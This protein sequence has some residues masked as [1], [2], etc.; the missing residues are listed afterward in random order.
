VQ[1]DTFVNY[2]H[3]RWLWV[4]VAFLAILVVLYV[5]DAPLKGPRG[6]TL[7][8][9]TYGGLATAGILYLMWY[10]KRKRSYRA[11]TTTLKGCLS[12]HVW[13]GISLAIIVPLH[14]GFSF[15]WNV[16]TLTY[17]LMMVV[18]LSGI[19]GAYH[20]VRL[21]PEIESHRGGGNLKKLLEQV[22]LLSSEIE[23]LIKD[24]SDAFL[25]LVREVDFPFEPSANLNTA[26]LPDPS[27]PRVTELASKLIETE[28][29][30]GLKLLS[31]VTK[32][33][34]FVSRISHEVRTTTRL[35]SWLYLHLPLSFA[36]LVC[37]AIHIFT[38]LYYR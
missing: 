37:L 2:R 27:N 19:W 5:I 26:K 13:L 16:H 33:R 36:L 18:V 1:V 34:E 29:S 17:I 3:Y 25:A 31:L 20:Y 4:N 28:R 8:G 6:H 14:A 24:K 7:L 30:D 35:K 21:A 9:Y 38:A 32:K 15:N 10:G 11:H 22:H 12:A 23:T